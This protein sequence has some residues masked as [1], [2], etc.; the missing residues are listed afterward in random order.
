[1]RFPDGADFLND[2]GLRLG[3]R[4]AVRL[5]PEITSSKTVALRN[6]C[7]NE[8]PGKRMALSLPCGCFS[9][10]RNSPVTDRIIACQTLTGR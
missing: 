10:R 8:L 4:E 7:F 3:R 9:H 6:D 1:M 2:R 5:R